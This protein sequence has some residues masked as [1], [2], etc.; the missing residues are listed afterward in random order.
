MDIEKAPRRGGRGASHSVRT[1]RNRAVF[2]MPG[3]LRQ[4]VGID[5]PGFQPAAVPPQPDNEVGEIA[6]LLPAP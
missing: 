2:S 5:L 1:A 6:I 3:S 4:P